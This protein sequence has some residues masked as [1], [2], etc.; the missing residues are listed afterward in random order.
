MTPVS[1]LSPSGNEPEHF[2]PKRHLP[3]FVEFILG[4]KGG[5]SSASICQSELVVSFVSIDEGE[6]DG[7]HKGSE[8]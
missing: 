1:Y 6:V 8:D 5:V 7:A 2:K 3:E 4:N